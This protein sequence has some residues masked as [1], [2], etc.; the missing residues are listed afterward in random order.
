MADKRDGMKYLA[1][2]PDGVE[3]LSMVMWEGNPLVATTDGIYLY[4]VINEVMR[5]QYYEIEVR[6]DK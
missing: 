4:D 6:G 5:K 2:F 1:S 3:I